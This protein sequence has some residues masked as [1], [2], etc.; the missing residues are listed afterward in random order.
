MGIALAIVKEEKVPW[1][2]LSDSNS[3]L[4]DDDASDDDLNESTELRQLL[5]SVKTVITSLFRLSMAI[6]DPAP[7]NQS[8]STITVDK[9]CY[10]QYDILHVKEKFKDSPDYLTER[11]GRAISGRRHYLSYREEHHKKLTNNIEKIGFE[12]PTTEFTTNST[13][14][15]P[16]GRIER[17]NSL[18]I[19]DEG[20]D[21]ASQ[22][23]YATSVNAT[24][25]VPRL[26]KEA[27]DKDFFECPLCFLLVSV[28]TEAEWNE[29]NMYIEIFIH[30]VV[31]LN[32]VQQLIDFT[33]LGG[34][35]SHMNWKPTEQFGNAS[36][37]V[38]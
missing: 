33:I 21:T 29:G 13:E 35:G 25:R 18:N 7:N 15:T 23:S 3:E 2:E 24:I 27:R 32:I 36:R 19:L 9:S 12:K 5:E 22:T 14:A 30:I 10:E 17:S 1:D 8:K 38:E 26:P 4:S 28:H 37:D 6:R 20:D 34:L 11:L 31:P 16:I